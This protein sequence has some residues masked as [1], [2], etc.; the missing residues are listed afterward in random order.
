[1]QQEPAEGEADRGNR[2]WRTPVGLSA[3]FLVL[4]CVFALTANRTSSHIDAHA[5]T[6]ESWRIATHGT[7]WLEGAM[8]ASMHQNKFIAEAAN[9]HI[10]G[11]RMAGPVIA[12]IP[13]YALFS[14]SAGGFTLGPGGLA[15]AW[16]TSCAVLL[17]FLALRPRLGARWSLAVTAVFAFGTPTWSVSADMLW[18]H[19]VTQLG[20]AGAAYAASRNRWWLVGILLGVG[21]LGRP[22]LAIVAAVLGAG[23]AWSRRDPRFLLRVGLPTATSL[24]ALLAWGRWMF[25]AWSIE[26]GGY[27]GK[28]AAAAQGFHGSE[29]W[30]GRFPQ[31]TNY[32]GFLV[33]PDRGFLVWSPIVLLVLPALVR[34]WRTIPVWSRWLAVGGVVYTM[35]QLRINYFAGGDGFYGYRLALELLTCVVPVLAFS[36][37]RLGS[38][39]RRLVPVV[40]GLQVGA[41]MLGAV[42]E[43]FQVQVAD[44]WRDNSVW[45]A[46]RMVPSVAVPWFLLWLVVGTV[47]STRLPGRSTT[48]ATNPRR[49]R[50]SDFPDDVL[51]TK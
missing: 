16:W 20:L 35:V 34:S 46:L 36:L 10:V 48:P 25:G 38:V 1:V 3:L 7:P 49:D 30:S 9:G 26:A 14:D 39:A 33:S 45:V 21:M 18:T 47:V 11:M 8:D 32:M 22:H 2:R 19:T 43:S 4:F 50:V 27:G 13:F 15:A 31:V 24:L 42:T 29:E 51:V 41:I 40:A 5:A 17:M 28:A 12:G 44:V 6:V 37:P 23:M